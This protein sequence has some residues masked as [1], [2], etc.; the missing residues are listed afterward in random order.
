LTVDDDA[1]PLSVI[2]RPRFGWVPRD[3]DRGE[4]QTAYELVVNEVPI[5]GGTPEPIWRSGKVRS[6][7]QSYVTPPRLKFRPEY[8]YTWKVRTWDASGRP[9]GFSKPGHFDVA[10]LQGN[11]QADWIRRPGAPQTPSE[12]FSLLRKKIAVGASPIVRARAYMSAG[13]QYDLRVNGTR[14]AHGPSFA[15]PDQQYYE[16]TDITRLLRAGAEN[17][18]AVVTHWST[19][20]QGRPASVPAFIARITIDHAD[21][22]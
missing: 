14:A 16:A 11:W 8:S 7:Q 13:Q 10:L 2:G 6:A 3:A 22:R 12:D 19:P 21:G 17:A 9:S 18:I 20:G 1:A 15:Y 5:G 4:V